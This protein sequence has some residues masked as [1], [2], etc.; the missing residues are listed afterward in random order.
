VGKKEIQNS[1]KIHRITPSDF[2]DWQTLALQLWPTTSPNEMKEILSNV[3]K[4]PK[5]EGFLI[6]DNA[7][8]AIAFMNL[9]LR[10]DYV[11]GARKSPVAYVEGI[12]VKETYR[13]QGIAA[14]L[15]RHAEQWALEKQCTELASDA[16]LENTDSQNFHTHVGFREVE[17]TVAYIKRIQVTTDS[18]EGRTPLRH[19]V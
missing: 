9:S 11:P 16:D 4:S 14:R 1:L 17:R 18:K 8:E 7:R 12:Y 3:F 2:S 13:K 10:Y 15:I 5:E 19:P 6:R